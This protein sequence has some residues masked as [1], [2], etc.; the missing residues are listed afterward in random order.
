VGF[1]HGVMN[2]DNMSILGLTIDYGPYG[3]IDD[4]DP[5]WTPNTTDAA[6]RRYRF[7]QQP[8]IAQWNLVRLAEAVAPV[9]PPGEHLQAGLDLFSTTFVTAYDSMNAAKFGVPEVHEDA[10][11]LM[12]DGFKL[13]YDAEVDYTNVFRALGEVPD[14]LPREGANAAALL[15]DV[16]YDVARRDT[17]ADALEAWFARWHQMVTARPFAVR[18]AAMHAVN[19]WLVLRNYVAQQAIDAA[20]AGDATLVHQLLDALRRPYEVQPAMAA[21]AARRPEWAK[22]KA[23][24]S[25][26]SCSS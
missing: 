10:K 11:Q 3:W 14:E 1:V 5:N 16:F 4:F 21:Y 13:F 26:L 6:G 17:H 20:H 8:S 19:P 9:M 15:G 7:G 22:H 12:R 2:T 25:M 24:C 18:R 23:G